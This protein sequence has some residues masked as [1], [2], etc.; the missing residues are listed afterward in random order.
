MANSLSAVTN[1]NFHLAKLLLKQL[2]IELSSNENKQALLLDAYGQAVV[3]HLQRTLQSLI[4]ELADRARASDEKM[5]DIVFEGTL[6]EIDGLPAELREIA[7]LYRNG[8]L[9][10][11]MR[12]E[13]LEHYEKPSKHHSQSIVVLHEVANN[14]FGFEEVQ[15]WFNRFDEL[16]DRFRETTV[17]C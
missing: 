13:R 8:W 17:E 10:Q 4:V 14:Y 12:A 16:L 7:V 2:S 11:L 1:H 15:Q 5:H 9:S 3:W 6:T